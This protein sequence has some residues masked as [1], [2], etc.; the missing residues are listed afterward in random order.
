M[1]TISRSW[2]IFLA[3]LFLLSLAALVVQGVYYQR[4]IA[5]AE[6]AVGEKEDLER[7]VSELEEENDEL[8]E[9]LEGEEVSLQD[10]VEKI[11]LLIKNKDMEGLATYVH[12]DKGVR[13]SPYGYVD[14]KNHLTFTSEQVKG[15]MEDDEEYTWGVYDGTGDPIKLTFR[16]YYNKFVYDVDFANAAVIGNNHVVGAG[17]TLINYDEAYPDARFV[18]FHFPGFEAQYEGLDWRSLRL[19]FEEKDNTWYLVGIVHDQW[20]I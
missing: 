16:E 8:K 12:P 7:R 1:K 14:T 20:T 15:L 5:D 17:N 6:K 4:R 13:F 3:V 9:K 18:E 10:R 11:I 2:F 19:F